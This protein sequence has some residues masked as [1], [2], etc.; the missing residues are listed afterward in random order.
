MSDPLTLLLDPT[1]DPTKSPIYI[2]AVCGDEVS[3][4]VRLA[5]GF[6]SLQMVEV[7]GIQGEN[8]PLTEP[9][10]ELLHAQVVHPHIQNSRP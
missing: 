10:H 8:D 2:L 1:A 7:I 5:K 4:A 6:V 3:L 9:G